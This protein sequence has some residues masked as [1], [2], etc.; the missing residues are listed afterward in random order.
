MGGAFTA[1]ANDGSATYW[2]PAGIGFN[3]LR[4]VYVNHSDW[5]AD[6]SFDYFMYP[7]DFKIFFS[8]TY[9]SIFLFSRIK[10]LLLLQSSSTFDDE[11]NFS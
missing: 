2:N 6:I 7:N 3:H 9:W 10:I 4:N 5:I 11:L 1:L 8:S